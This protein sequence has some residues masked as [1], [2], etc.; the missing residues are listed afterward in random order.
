MDLSPLKQKHYRNLLSGQAVSQFGDYLYFLIFLYMVKAITGSD[1]MVG[2]VAAVQ[3][4]PVLLLSPYAG[5]LADRMDRRKLMLWSDIA[6]AAIMFLF[7]L[8]LVVASKPSLVVI[9]AAAILLATVNTFFLPAKSAAIPRLVAEKDLVAANS[10]SSSVQHMMPMLGLVLSAVTLGQLEQAFPS[11]MFPVA[12]ILNGLTFVG[13][14]YFLSR[15]P[16][17]VPQRAVAPKSAWVDSV[18]GV[19]WTVKHSTM[20]IILIQALLTQ[21][22]I[23]PF[24][25]AHMHVNQAWFKGNYQTIATFEVAFL[26]SAFVMS[27]FLS[28][29]KILRPGVWFMVNCSLI[30]LFVAAMGFAPVY[31]PYLLL[32]V[33]CGLLFPLIVVPIQTYVQTTVEDG[34]LGR[35]NAA[36]GM[37]GMAAIPV[38][39]AFAGQFLASYGPKVLFLTM[40]FGML[41]ATLIGLFSKPYIKAEIPQQTSVASERP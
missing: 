5:A 11:A 39:N 14:A 20:R 25:V 22:F 31:A 36:F 34:M 32:N 6:S 1:T 17:I 2:A 16:S 28:R 26:G 12:A 3:A 35:V 29:L 19:K 37:V 7:A 38:S 15:L 4:I 24:M 13:S 9:F 40:G 18:E 27:L 30:S 41:T 10:L 33:A 21:F 8:H 23:A